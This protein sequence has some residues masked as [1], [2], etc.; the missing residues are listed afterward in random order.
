[1][2]GT[3]RRR[4]DLKEEGGDMFTPTFFVPMF[5][6]TSQLGGWYI[7][8][9][10]KQGTKFSLGQ[11]FYLPPGRRKVPRLSIPTK[12]SEHTLFHIFYF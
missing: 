11:P 3:G 9:V 10:F 4:R 6:P 1:M 7:S 2:Q 12:R 5:M 8:I